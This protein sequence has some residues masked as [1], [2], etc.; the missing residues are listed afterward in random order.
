MPNQKVSLMDEILAAD[1]QPTDLWMIARPNVENFKLSHAEFLS[2]IF[3]PIFTSQTVFVDPTF[4]NDSTGLRER[5]DKPFQSIAAAVTE[6]VF[7]DTIILLSGDHFIFSNILKDGVNFYANVGVNIYC[8][9]IFLNADTTAGGTLLTTPFQ[10]SGY[11]NI[12]QCSGNLVLTKSNPNAVINL[13]LQSAVVNNI[14][15]GVLVFDG[16]VNLTVREFYTC[17]GRN[18]SMRLTGNLTANIGGAVTNTFANVSNGCFWISGT[19][20]VG[21]ANIKAK[22][23]NIP[24]NAIG[25][26]S[27][28]VYCDNLIGSETNIELDELIDTSAVAQAAIRINNAF[29]NTGGKIRIKIKKHSSVRPLYGIT[30]AVSNTILEIT[31]S[32]GG[33]SIMTAG[34]LLI[35]NSLVKNLSGSTI[36]HAGGTLSLMASTIVSDGIAAAINNTAGNVLSEGSK[37][38]VAPTNPVIGNLYINPLYTN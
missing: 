13:E 5:N 4:G 24:T 25:G 23:F 21:T 36:S 35:K 27:C 34:E 8:F 29:T 37:A 38:N 3:A 11:A 26:F 2:L 20:W 30:N 15:N 32:N 22:S 6:A 18:F 12:K 7:G 9:T 19:A 33:Q 10:F 28:H 16:L 1:L 31:E 17:A 14:S